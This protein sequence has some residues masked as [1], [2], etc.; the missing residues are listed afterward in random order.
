V[1]RHIAQGGAQAHA[2]C[3][4]VSRTGLLLASVRCICAPRDLSN[5]RLRWVTLTGSQRAAVAGRWAR[6]AA[7]TITASTQPPDCRA[8]SLTPHCALHLQNHLIYKQLGPPP[9]LTA[10]AGLH[11]QYQILRRTRIKSHLVDGVNALLES[12]AM[13]LVKVG[14]APAQSCPCS[15]NDLHKAGMSSAPCCCC[16][17]PC[18]GRMIPAHMGERLRGHRRG[19]NPG[20][21]QGCGRDQGAPSWSSSDEHHDMPRVTLAPCAL[22]RHRAV[23]V[24]QVACSHLHPAPA[25]RW[26]RCPCQLQCLK[27]TGSTRVGSSTRLQ[28][29]TWLHD[30][31]LPTNSAPLWLQMLLC[32]CL[33]TNS[34]IQI[35][36]LFSPFW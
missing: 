6:A 13:V 4:P 28:L 34:W 22:A 27:P 15:R 14:L 20:A 33:E 16:C 17:A 23:C 25:H 10:T 2:L 8:T 36:I 12:T 35:R 19:A 11:L 21:T 30:G 29:H 31:R 9:P 1:P 7:Q 26:L 5:V 3:F 24:V 32:W 18:L